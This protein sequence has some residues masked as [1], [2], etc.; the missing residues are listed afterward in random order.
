[1]ASCGL[2]GRARLELAVADFDQL[3][4]PGRLGQPDHH[5]LMLAVGRGRASPQ[6][7]QAESPHPEALRAID[8][9]CGA[10]DPQ[11]SGA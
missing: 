4:M 7:L 1:M 10:G 2:L 8:V 11:V 3:Q 6:H 9:G 5:Q